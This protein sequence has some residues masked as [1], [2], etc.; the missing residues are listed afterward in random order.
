MLVHNSTSSEALNYNGKLCS[1]SGSTSSASSSNSSNSNSNSSNS[2]SNQSFSPKTMFDN[3]HHHGDAD[4]NNGVSANGLPHIAAG[5]SDDTNLS[6]LP[7]TVA[8]KQLTATI[9]PT[10]AVSSVPQTFSLIALKT[11]A[12]ANGLS[13]SHAIA[14]AHNPNKLVKLHSDCF[15]AAQ[16]LNGKAAAKSLIIGTENN[17]NNNNILDSAITLITNKGTSVDSGT[18]KANLPNLGTV[19]AV[20]ATTY[21]VIVVVVES[22]SDFHV[23]PLPFRTNITQSTWA[24]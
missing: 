12:S 17:R 11:I 16:L 24:S 10:T 3:H 13:N 23:F 1:P 6:A 7:T 5:V 19:C 22:F 14:S 15:D 21:G 4:T 20:C 18:V 9:A 2:N 8:G